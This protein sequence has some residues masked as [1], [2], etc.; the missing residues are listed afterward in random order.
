MARGRKPGERALALANGDVTYIGSPCK[1]CKGVERYAC[2][3][4]CIECQSGKR[5]DQVMAREDMGRAREIALHRGA[6]TYTNHSPCE[7][8]RTWERYTSNGGCIACAKA[9]TTRARAIRAAL[10]HSETSPIVWINSP[11]S[12]ET[13][14][15]YA[16]CPTL[17]AYGGQWHAVYSDA[18]HLSPGARLF[19][20]CD[21]LRRPAA[22][23]M[24]LND[25]T[26][27]GHDIAQHL[28][29][30]YYAALSLYNQ[31]VRGIS[32]K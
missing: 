24:M 19:P 3:G 8:C 26:A 11:P 14:A 6:V 22:L 25:K 27:P 4:G 2:N 5:S 7:T 23:Q 12:D 18:Q 10:W 9:R 15:L 16:M 30:A 21:V 32:Q 28:A 31:K 20:G 1:T 29:P 13:A 17:A